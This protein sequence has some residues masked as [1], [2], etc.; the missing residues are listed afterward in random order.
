MDEKDLKEIVTSNLIKYRKAHNYTQATLAEKINYSDKAISKW[1]R[2]ESI[3]DLYTL[4][5]LANLY[6]ITLNDLVTD[7]ENIKIKP[8]KEKNNRFKI[9]LLSYLLVWLVATIFY[10]IPL[11]FTNIPHLWL[12]FIFAIP[13]SFIVLLVFSAL[14]GSNKTNFLC[15]TGLIL[16]LI[17]AI[18]MPLY[19]CLAIEKIWLL[20]ILFAPTELLNIF[21]FLIKK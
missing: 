14:W 15:V 12:T 21:W 18:C 10:V 16:S 8:K 13:I 2:G 1:E 5:L 11:I 6:N 19:I 4:Q 17:L 20:F 9:T 3:P 7:C